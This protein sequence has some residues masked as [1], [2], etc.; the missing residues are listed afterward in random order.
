MYSLGLILFELYQPFHTEM[1]RLSSLNEARK[2]ILPAAFCDKWPSQVCLLHSF[3]Q[4][5]CPGPTEG[6]DSLLFNI[7]LNIV[8]VIN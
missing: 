3:M 4:M 1:E 8:N 7:L 5:C 2:G 6:M